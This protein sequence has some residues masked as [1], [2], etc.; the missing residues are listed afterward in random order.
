MRVDSRRRNPVGTVRGALR[1]AGRNA[2]ARA[3][4]RAGTAPRIRAVRTDRGS[5]DHR[6]LDEGTPTTRATRTGRTPH[7]RCC[8]SPGESSTGCGSPRGR[9]R[10]NGP[11][12]HAQ[13]A[14]RG[15]NAGT[16]P[17]AGRELNRG[18]GTRAQR[19]GRDRDV[20]GGRKANP[21]H[22]ARRGPRRK[23]RERRDRPAPR[24]H[25]GEPAHRGT[26]RT[27][28]QERHRA[29]Q[30]ADR[31]EE[32]HRASEADRSVTEAVEAAGASARDEHDGVA[33]R[34][35]G[36]CETPSAAGRAEPHPPHLRMPPRRRDFPIVFALAGNSATTTSVLRTSRRGCIP[37][38]SA[39]RDRSGRHR[40]KGV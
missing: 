21:E 40:S 23:G 13:G 10:C 33:G 22:G 37:A 39:M 18:G 24:A 12:P 6:A 11:S 8:G 3:R 35:E 25:R 16:T 5:T 4:T 38:R 30:G 26:A 32:T 1:R 34:I 27:G 20:G 19:D 14:W 36:K 15:A 31:G 2:G 17:W 28:R 9:S 7:W 29:A